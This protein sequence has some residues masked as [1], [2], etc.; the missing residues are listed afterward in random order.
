MCPNLTLP[1]NLTNIG[2]A[3][4]EYIMQGGGH[5]VKTNGIQR[6]KKLKNHDKRKI[7]KLHL[8][9]LIAQSGYTA[10]YKEFYIFVQ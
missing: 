1:A 4:A 3:V 9:V 7:V 10:S 6:I 2:R 5:L 8:K